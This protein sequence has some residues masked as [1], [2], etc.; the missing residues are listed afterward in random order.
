MRKGTSPRRPLSALRA[1]SLTLSSGCVDGLSVCRQTV[2]A[3]QQ[4]CSLS[5]AMRHMPRRR[6]RRRM[7]N[8]EIVE[9]RDS[10]SNS[11]TI[12]MRAKLNNKQY[13][14]TTTVTLQQMFGHG[15]ISGVAEEATQQAK[16]RTRVTTPLQSWRAA[17][18]C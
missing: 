14:S 17:E 16:Y 3:Q 12:A 1:R 18:V 6:R 11:K 2:P 7:A 9:Q 13:P 10:N 8:G 5:C 15:S 4:L